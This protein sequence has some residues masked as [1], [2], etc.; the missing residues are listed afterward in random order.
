[1]SKYVE[2]TIYE[3]TMD[4][5]DT[6]KRT[7]DIYVTAETVR[8][9]KHRKEKEHP[10]TT[11][12]QSPQHTGSDPVKKRGSRAATVCLGLLCVLLLAA[13]IVLCVMF[14]QEREWIIF[15]NDNLTKER[16]QLKREKNEFQMTL[17]KVDGWIYYQFSFYYISSE[18]ESWNESRIYCTERGADLLIIN[19]TKEQ[20]FVKN[21]TVGSIMWIGLTDSDEE[22]TWKWVDG[23]TL[24][25]GFWGYMEPNGNT[26]ENCALTLSSKLADYPWKGAER[27]ECVR[28]RSSR[29]AAVCLGLLCVLLAA[30]IVLCVQ[31]I[32]FYIE[33]KNFT[34]ERD[35]LLTKNTNL[36]EEKKKKTFC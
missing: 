4:T 13:V 5:E 8:D 14:T 15:K 26:G 21:I 20:E 23:S 12:I 35:Q 32:Y 36:T 9:I 25:A 16:D 27:R 6:V 34:Q 17:G 30:V 3:S 29:A 28:N 19:N 33:S 24:T 31:I 10:K 18:R 7:V 1:M 11:T 2:N 22:G